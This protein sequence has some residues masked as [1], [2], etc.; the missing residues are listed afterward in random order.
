MRKFELSQAVGM[1]F[2]AENATPCRV[3]VAPPDWG[4]MVM[5]PCDTMTNQ[6]TSSTVSST[7]STYPYSRFLVQC[8]TSAQPGTKSSRRAR[9]VQSEM[10]MCMCMYKC[11][12]LLM[13]THQSSRSL[14]RAL[15]KVQGG[16]TRCPLIYVLC[17]CPCPWV[18]WYAPYILYVRYV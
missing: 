9:R 6:A 8:H 5:N 4:D 12:T 7:D 17:P 1:H 2:H 13:P 16:C 15:S 10:C 14:G 3:A 11:V 18:R